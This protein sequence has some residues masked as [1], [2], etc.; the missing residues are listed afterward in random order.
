M[1]SVFRS[2][3]FLRLG[4]ITRWGLVVLDSQAL[5][6]LRG[7]WR[8]AGHWRRRSSSVV[9]AMPRSLG[10]LVAPSEQG[11]LAAGPAPLL[12]TALLL[13]CIAFRANQSQALSPS[14]TRDRWVF[15][16]SCRYCTSGR[17][18]RVD[19]GHCG[20]KAILGTVTAR[21]HSV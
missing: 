14:C 6:E 20:K 7:L 19:N 15:P 3:C 4:L 8:P 21:S 17:G 12:H 9:R 1:C 10:S 18:G 16:S 5:R 11:F 13:S 2:L